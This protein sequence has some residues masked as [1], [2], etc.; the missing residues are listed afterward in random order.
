MGAGIYLYRLTVG[1][2]RQTERM[3]LIDGQVEVGGGTHR[4]HDQSTPVG[5]EQVYGLAV[6]G[7]DMATCVVSDFRVQAGMAPVEVVVEARDSSMRLKVATSG[8]LGDVDGNGRVDIVD[9]LLVAMYTVDSSITSTNIPNIALADVDQDGDIDF[10][11][12]YFIG[13]YS[14]NPFDSV[15][16]AGIGQVLEEDHGDS[17]SVATRIS[18]GSTTSGSLSSGDTDY[19]RVSVSSSGT[20]VAYTTGSTDTYGYIED[21]SGRVLDSND[22]AGEDT[23]FWVS[24]SVSSGTYY[25][26]VRGYDNATAFGG[27]GVKVGSDKN[28]SK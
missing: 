3:V 8:I 2:E 20:L 22:D 23:N 10:V 25:I 19:F 4:L 16:P 11:D 7:R 9:A 1:G 18:L 27:T 24:A 28:H 5:Q 17:R 12:A 14:V 13:T 21:S 15:L 6:S 26:R